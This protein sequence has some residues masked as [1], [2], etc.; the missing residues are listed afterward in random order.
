MKTRLLTVLNQC[1]YNKSLAD[2][3]AIIKLTSLLNDKD[4]IHASTD[5]EDYGVNDSSLHIHFRDK[6]YKL[7]TAS[8]NI[9]N[10]I[11]IHLGCN[12]IYT[13]LNCDYNI[14]YNEIK[15]ILS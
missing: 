15:A 13:M 14:Q 5:T 10:Y 11:V 4:T 6:N 2:F 9:N 1:I 7:L 3:E 12:C 8:F